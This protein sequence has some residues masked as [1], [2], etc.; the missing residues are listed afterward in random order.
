MQYFYI[1][2]AG[3]VMDKVAMLGESC[4]QLLHL[5]WSGKSMEEVAGLLNIT[6]GYARKKKSRC[7]AKL[8]TL[9]KQSPEFDS[10]KW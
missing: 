3:P 5:S 7:M 1:I 6:Y 10:L 2:N 9:V 8:V 4:R